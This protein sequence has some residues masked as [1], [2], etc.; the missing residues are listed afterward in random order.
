MPKKL[1]LG[2]LQN[3]FANHIF[4]QKNILIIKDLPYSNQEALARLNIYR[5][6][7]F[8]NFDAVLSSIYE[9]VTKIIGEKKFTK[10]ALEY[11]KKFPSINGN[12]DDY[13]DKLPIFLKKHQLPFL[14]DLAR[15][16]LY[17]HQCYFAADVKVF[18]IKKFQKLAPEKFFDLTLTLHPS[19]FLIKSKFAI[20]SIWKKKSAKNIQIN[21]PEYTLIERSQDNCQIHRLSEIEFVFLDNLAKKKNL[22]FIYKKICKLTNGEF[23]IGVMLNRFIATGIIADFSI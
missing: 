12:L 1:L 8:G 11:H 6:N 21:R 14:S 5:N 3:N 19:C 13:G 18:D 15:L 10:L 23:D 4:D 22:Y 7:V 17:Y 20:F 16:E 2:K 9:V